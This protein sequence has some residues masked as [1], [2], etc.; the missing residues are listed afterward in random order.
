MAAATSWNS[1][2]IAEATGIALPIAGASLSAST[3]PS[4]TAAV[5]TSTASE[6]LRFSAPYALTADVAA[7]A[8][9]FV[10]PSPIADA[11][12]EALRTSIAVDPLRPA[13]AIKNIASAN[14]CGPL[15]VALA[16][17]FTASPNF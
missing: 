13:E 8:T 1:I 15:P 4:R 10:W 3:L 14:S 9:A 16:A 17:C 6:P 5:S 7:S 12:A 11:F 2:P